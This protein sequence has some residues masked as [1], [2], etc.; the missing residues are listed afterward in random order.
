MKI[1]LWFP[2]PI[3]IEENILDDCENQKLCDRI[4]ELKTQSESGGKNWLCNT[5]NTLGSI[6]IKNDECG[7]NCRI[8]IY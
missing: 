5:Y 6:D 3:Y 7:C 2:T 1:D 4:L 8:S